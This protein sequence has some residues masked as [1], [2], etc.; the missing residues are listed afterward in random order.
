MNNSNKPRGLP[1]HMIP[2]LS[3]FQHWF[4]PLTTAFLW[5]ISACGHE[6]TAGPSP[7]FLLSKQWRGKEKTQ[8]ITAQNAAMAQW[9]EFSILVKRYTPSLITATTWDS[10]VWGKIICILRQ[11]SEKTTIYLKKMIG[12]FLLL[13]NSGV[14]FSRHPFFVNLHLSWKVQIIQ[15]STA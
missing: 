2:W 15:D 12:D 9:N 14:Y 13:K 5:H 7:E 1:Q 10:T 6:G 4:P 11:Q 3:H 8:K